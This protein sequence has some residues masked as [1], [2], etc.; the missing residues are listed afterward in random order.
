MK[1]ILILI[2]FI[3][4]LFTLA[5]Q[6]ERKFGVK[7][8]GYVKS[9]IFYDSRQ[10]ES[11]REGHFLLYPSPVLYDKDSNDINAKSSF[12]MLSI[13]TRLS[14][15][16]TGPDILGAET[17]GLVEGEFFGSTD[18]DINGFRLRH[19]FLKLDW[20]HHGVI[21]GQTWHPMFV[22]ESF[23]SVVSV[24]TGAPFQPFSRNPQIRYTL[25]YNFFS[26]LVTAMSQRDFSSPG[27]SMSLRNSVIPDIFAQ[28]KFSFK[29]AENNNEVLFGLGGG[30]K[31]LMPR[32]KTDSGY[33]TDATVSGFY[34]S[35]YIKVKTKPLTFKLEGTYGQ[36]LFNLTMLGGYAIKYDTNAYDLKRN[37]LNYT[38]LDNVAGWFEVMTNGAKF[39]A[40]LFAGYSYNL[41]S[42][43]NIQNWTKESSYFTRGRNILYCYRISPRVLYNINK[44]RI[45]LELEYTVA[46]YGNKINSLGQVSD[47]T[48][49][50]NFRTLLGVF[51]YF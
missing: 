17:S 51:Y 49:V 39:Q 5:Q 41:G 1:K 8:S 34:G 26:F 27:G 50:S 33:K 7:L 3:L 16:I 11:M 15:N 2:V 32:I 38:T 36:N 25:K 45:A 44:V 14:C 43:N 37:Y 23:P 29:N 48:P 28:A 13:Q 30:Y 6:Q 35:A 10:V 21:V 42:L 40:G 4:P 18:A 22:E 20:K 46:G 31:V 24:N 47:I 12:N 19:A 9:D